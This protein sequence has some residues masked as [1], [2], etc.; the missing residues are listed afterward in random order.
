VTFSWSAVSDSEGGISG[1]HLFAGT[2]VSGSN[3]FN[4]VVTATSNTVSGSYGQTLY[5]RVASV[6][7]AGIESAVS[8]AGAGTILL[9][10]AA[11]YDGDGQSNQAE[12][13]AGTNPL[14][15]SSVLRILAYTP[16]T[17]DLVWASVAGKV[18]QVKATLALTSSFVPLGG[19]VTAAAATAVY[20]DVTATNTVKFYR[21][22]VVP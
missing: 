20:Q 4:G 17:H 1:Y 6:N 11:D 14:D 10:P 9:D 16:A 8:G 13:I 7:H 3:S 2:N 22:Q 19:A 15:G 5:A 18:Y 12:V 21:V